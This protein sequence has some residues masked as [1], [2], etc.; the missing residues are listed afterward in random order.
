MTEVPDWRGVER[1]RYLRF[2][3]SLDVSQHPTGSEEGP[4]ED[5]T[6]DIS[7]GGILL[8]SGH[9][10]PAG[11]ELE[12]LVSTPSRKARTPMRGIVLRSEMSP[13]DGNFRIGI[14]FDQ[15]LP[16][17]DEEIAI[18]LPPLVKGLGGLTNRTY[19]RLPCRLPLDFRR[20]WFSQWRGAETR[21]L[22]LGGTLFISPERVWKD[23]RIHLRIKL[24]EDREVRTAA[25]VVAVFRRPDEG[26]YLVSVNFLDLSSEEI[27]LVG[28]FVSQEL[29]AGDMAQV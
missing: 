4:S 29:G 26:G 7:I 1:R 14:E 27:D 25:R 28:Q 22:S 19:V 15:V 21:D 20:F 8:V 3:E 13:K 24:G 17:R 23:T 6:E 16:A 18:F 11:T 9:D 5:T 10:I 2:V 12:L